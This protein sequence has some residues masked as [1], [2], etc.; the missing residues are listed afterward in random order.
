M[1]LTVVGEFGGGGTK[2]SHL[3]GNPIDCG[4]WDQNP[5]GQVSR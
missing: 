3:G 1:T 5:A 4:D 2:P